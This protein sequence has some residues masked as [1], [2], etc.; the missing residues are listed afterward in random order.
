MAGHEPT[1]SR[2]SLLKGA[3]A[4]FLLLSRTSAQSAAPIPMRTINH[5]HLIV[6]DLQRS[7]DFYQK[8]F[9]LR[10]AGMQGV[11]SDWSKPVIPML[12][13]GGGPQFIS[14]SEGAGRN[15][16]RDRIDHFG[17]GV[18][19]FNAERVVKMLAAHGVKS[20]VRMRADSKPP[21]PELKFQDP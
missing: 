21:V 6:S 20:N 10:L 13:I 16:G 4:P 11:E 8:L 9:G 2:R 7:L 17:F 5:V 12:A 18:D 15:G 14:F 1:V 19:K 3:I